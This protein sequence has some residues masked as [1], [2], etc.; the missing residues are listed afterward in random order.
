MICSP[1]GALEVMVCAPIATPAST[2]LVRG[3]LTIDHPD[4]P[5]GLLAPESGAPSSMTRIISS[6]TIV[7]RSCW[8]LRAA[9]GNQSRI[10][11]NS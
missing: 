7:W 3:V 9:A 10:L 6:R 5:M 8:E 1:Q 11:S 2:L 4:D